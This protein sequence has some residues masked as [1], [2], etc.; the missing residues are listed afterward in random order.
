MKVRRC[1]CCHRDIE[2]LS[3]R[4]FRKEKYYF[5][6]EFEDI[7]GKCTHYDLCD[8]CAKFIEGTI[9]IGVKPIWLGIE[10]KEG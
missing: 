2:P 1:D 8:R 5:R 3:G 7:P 10:P 4:F 6:A 9:K